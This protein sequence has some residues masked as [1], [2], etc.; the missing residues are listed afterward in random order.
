[1]PW[2][3]I[4]GFQN[5]MVTTTIV[6]GKVLMRNGEILSLDEEKIIHHAKKLAP[7]VWERYAQQF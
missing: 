1:L 5:S 2:H 6:D 3:V 7:N 4:F